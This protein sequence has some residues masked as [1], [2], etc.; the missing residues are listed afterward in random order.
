MFVI[1]VIFIIAV[2][3]SGECDFSLCKLPLATEVFDCGFLSFSP[4]INVV[5]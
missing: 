1:L 4:F 3:W 5:Q 2:C